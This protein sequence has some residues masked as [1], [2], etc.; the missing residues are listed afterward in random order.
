[1]PEGEDNEM[2]DYRVG[3]EISANKASMCMVDEQGAIL[4]RRVFGAVSSNSA[5]RFTDT[6]CDHL[7]DMLLKRG[8]LPGD[9]RH[10]GVGITACV[11]GALSVVTR[12]PDG[13]GDNPVPLAH[14]MEGR[15][16]V[17]PMIVH[18]AWATANA[19]S[20]FGFGAPQDFL[21]VVLGR[22]TGAV[23]VRG[24]KIC[25]HT[26]TE[27]RRAA[28]SALQNNANQN[29][30]TE[31]LV[32]R[33]KARFVD[34]FQGEKASARDV[35]AHAEAGEPEWIAL[36]ND[37]AESFAEALL[38]AMEACDVK[39]AVIGGMLSAYQA[40][41]IDPLCAAVQ[42]CKHN[43]LDDMPSYAVRQAKFG[44]DSVMVGA[45]FFDKQMLA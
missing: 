12:A 35:L 45:A 32:R 29:I 44:A 36:L 15:I 30:S 38:A 33:A 26:C 31:A 7:E 1:M 24:G 18:A 23:C 11:D 37:A 42:R 3:M 13:L 16:G 39:E 25:L 17:M 22:E 4:C 5:E 41:L 43:G 9:V 21:C 20:R 14:L 40:H 19:E 2:A 10:I 27:A 34:V 28:L 8:M 6:L